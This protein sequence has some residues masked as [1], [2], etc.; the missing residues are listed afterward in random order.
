M[1][2]YHSLQ[3]KHV[4]TANEE[5]QV[6]LMWSDRHSLTKQGGGI[7]PVKTCSFPH[8]TDSLHVWKG[9]IHAGLVWPM[10]LPKALSKGAFWTSVNSVQEPILVFQE[11]LSGYESWL[12]LFEV[13]I[14]RSLTPADWASFIQHQCGHARSVPGCMGHDSSVT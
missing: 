6:R 10:Q 1:K 4:W 5:M 2:L 9:L 3:V 13:N 8:L 7:T 11:K 12:M 14:F